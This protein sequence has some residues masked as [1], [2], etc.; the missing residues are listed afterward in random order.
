MN[1]QYVNKDGLIC[2]SPELCL[3]LK[4]WLVQSHCMFLCKAAKLFLVTCCLNGDNEWVCVRLRV[5]LS[6]EGPY[7]LENTLYKCSPLTNLCDSVRTV[8]R[9]QQWTSTFSLCGEPTK[10]CVYVSTSTDKSNTISGS[11]LRATIN[12]NK[13]S[14]VCVCVCVCVCGELTT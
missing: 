12:D 7:S 13:L 2:L 11:C 1:K 3:R 6:L 14:C 8:L 4:R 10:Q 9:V 5:R